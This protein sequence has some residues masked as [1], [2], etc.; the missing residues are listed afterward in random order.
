MVWGSYSLDP[1]HLLLISAAGEVSSDH[2]LALSLAYNA[3]ASRRFGGIVERCAHV[4][5][6]RRV[7]KQ[8]RTRPHRARPPHAGGPDLRAARLHQSVSK[9]CLPLQVRKCGAETTTLRRIRV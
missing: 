1:S 6:H 4:R 5:G 8:L 2:R 9:T 3:I 7:P